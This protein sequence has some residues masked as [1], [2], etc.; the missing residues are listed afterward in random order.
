MGNKDGI[1]CDTPEEIKQIH[2]DWY[3]EL[4]TTKEAETELEKQ[5]E[6]IMAMVWRS[7]QA[8][9]SNQSPRKT[10]VEQVEEVIE[11]GSQES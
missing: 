6:E 3:K 8:I 2:A 1:L 4:L 10:T 7:M 5:A 11:I 9:A